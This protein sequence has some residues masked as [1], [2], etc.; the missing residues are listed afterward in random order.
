MKLKLLVAAVALASANLASAATVLIFG[1]SSGP[2]I[3]AVESAGVTTISSVNGPL[4]ITQIAD[5]VVNPLVGFLNLNM[6]SIDAAIVSGLGNVLTQNYAGGFSITSL[7][8][9]AGVNILSATFGNGR[10]SGRTGGGAL[11]FGDSTPVDGLV[12]TSDLIPVGQL[13]LNRATTFSFT[14]LS[15]LVTLAD[16]SLGS[17]TSNFSG[18]DSAKL[19]G[20]TVPEPSTL[21]LGSLGLLGVLT[22]R[23]A[24]KA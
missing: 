19:T 5:G 11:E 18:N 24:K 1:Q 22:S 10:I 4:I 15:S 6:Y 3:S 21:L 14:N 16:N 23:R 9:G 20:S 7:A 17:F 2:S 13:G 8:G 12:F